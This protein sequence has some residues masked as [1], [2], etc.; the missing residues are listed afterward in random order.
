M[1]RIEFDDFWAFGCLSRKIRHAS[2]HGVSRRIRVRPW[3]TLANQTVVMVKS[4]MIPIRFRALWLSSSL[5]F[6]MSSPIDISLLLGR[7]TI[8]CCVRYVSSF[9]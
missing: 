9:S 1:K 2:A 6:A 8:I 5:Y 7:R 3:W 4:I